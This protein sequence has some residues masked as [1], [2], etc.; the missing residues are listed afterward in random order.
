MADVLRL[1][2]S[3]SIA[4]LCFTALITVSGAEPRWITGTYK[5]FALGYS[6]DIPPGIKAITGDQAGPERGVLISLPSGGSITVYGEPNSLEWK[7]SSEG[8]SDELAKLHC[9]SGRQEVS[10][11]R[12]GKVQGAL[13]VLQCG[14]R[15]TKVL[16]ALRPGG[17]LVYSVRLDTTNASRHEDEEVLKNLAATFRVIAWR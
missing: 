4:I 5:N 11:S 16:L 1:T 12:L 17:G 14:S 10:I 13:G 3:A 7:T 2:K 6:I 15:V 8:V 9:D